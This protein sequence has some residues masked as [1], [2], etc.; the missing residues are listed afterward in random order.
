MSAFAKQN[1]KDDSDSD[2]EETTPVAE[3]QMAAAPE[4]EEVTTTANSDVQTK[5]MEAAKIANLV[6]QEVMAGVSSASMSR[7][8]NQP[9]LNFNPLTD[10]TTVSLSSVSVL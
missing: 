4:P 10:L 8:G 1:P 3:P 5:Y 2:A 6:L 7:G 9:N